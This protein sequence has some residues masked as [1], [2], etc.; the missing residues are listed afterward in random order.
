MFVCFVYVLLGVN[1]PEIPCIPML[2]HL[3]LKWVRLTKPQPFK[4]FLC[5][6]LRAF[7]M[8]NCAGKRDSSCL[9]GMVE[10]VGN[11]GLLKSWNSTFWEQPLFD[12][13]CWTEI[14]P[15]PVPCL[16]LCASVGFLLCRDMCGC[17]LIHPWDNSWRSGQSALSFWPCCVQDPQTLWS[18]F[19]WWQAWL[20][21]G[22][23]STWNWSVF[24]FLEGLSSTW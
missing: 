10:H 1:V 17:V 22:I 3:Y 15:C 9:K 20:L 8:R 19:P 4:D 13:W 2:R 6:S 12:L 5:I 14:S 7:V 21:P 11:L 16:V 23:W 24:H 18:T